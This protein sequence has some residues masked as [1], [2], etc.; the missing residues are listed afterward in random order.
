MLMS[1]YVR[2]EDCPDSS[3]LVVAF[4]HVGY[5]EGKFAFSNAISHIKCKKLFLNCPGNSWYQC[6]IPG[7]GQSIS[8]AAD[9]IKLFIDSLRV[10]RVIFVGMSMGG[11]AAI[12]FGLLC[13][14]KIILSFTAEIM[15]GLSGGRSVKENRVQFYDPRFSNLASLI[16]ANESSHI[17]LVYGEDDLIDLSLLWPISYQIL[18]GRRVHFFLSEGGHQCTLDLNLPLILNSLILDGWLGARSIHPS[19]IRDYA[20]SVQEFFAYS[21]IRDL[22]DKS[23][24]CAALELID[25]LPFLKDRHNMASLRKRLSVVRV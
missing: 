15:V 3:T 14:A 13:K 9:R 10:D 23:D 6:G 16:Y 1:N 7:V 12:L 25:S 19:R 2:F 20:F 24:S 11:Y 17:F 21:A 5:P 22:I 8:S 4:S 18:D